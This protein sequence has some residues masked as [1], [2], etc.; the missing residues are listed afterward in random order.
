M[1]AFTNRNDLMIKFAQGKGYY[2]QAGTTSTG[3]SAGAANS[4]GFTVQTLF[5]TIGSS[6]PGTLVGFPT[7]P[8][9]PAN[10][11][12]LMSM[13]NGDSNSGRGVW[14]CYFYKIGTIDLTGTGDKFTHDAA[15]FPITRTQFGA[16]A[17]PLTLLPFIYVTTASS[18]TAPAFQLQ[19]NGGAAGYTNQD[20]T[21]VIGTKTFTFPATATTTTSGYFMRPEDGDSGVQDISQTKVTTASTTGAASVYGVE[22]IAPM[23][24]L[25]LSM[26]SMYDGA[27]SGIGLQDLAPGVATSGT[28]TSMLGLIVM[29]TTGGIA[30]GFT[31]IG[32]LNN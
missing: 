19:T 14:L 27:F 3:G 5:N 26:A 8:A 24:C 9:L 29:S 16:S 25:H 12:I 21:T 1:S 23:G 6:V 20:G 17:K 10:L 11:S 22:L 2:F 7:P 4:G 31:I 15:G 18:V 13:F 30:G 32:V 28:A